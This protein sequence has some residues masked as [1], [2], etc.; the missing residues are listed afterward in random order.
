MDPKRFAE[1]IRNKEIARSDQR[2]A[3][4]ERAAL[5]DEADKKIRA[6]ARGDFDA[7]RAVA[8]ATVQELNRELGRQRFVFVQVAGGWGIQCG[9][10]LATF[11]YSQ[12]FS[13]AGR[14]V[15]AVSIQRQLS[16]LAAF[17]YDEPEPTNERRLTY[18][19]AWDSDRDMLL[20]V[21]RGAAPITK[22]DLIQEVL[23]AL[24]DR[25]H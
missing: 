13:N 14:I 4:R 9:R 10:E 25:D 22:D 7:M 18:E 20:W 16:T 24:A 6:S 21:R 5:H 12:L 3:E 8:E 1:R 11:V 23:E 2:S 17:G 15:L 19:P